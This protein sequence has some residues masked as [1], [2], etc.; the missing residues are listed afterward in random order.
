MLL[1]PLVRSLLMEHRCT[2]TRFYWKLSQHIFRYN[3][4]NAGDSTN[5]LGG[6]HTV[7][8]CQFS[9]KKHLCY[10]SNTVNL[11]PS[12]GGRWVLGDDPFLYHTYPQ[13]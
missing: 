9:C 4:H 5:S 10:N 2:D 12:Q 11:F 8:E 7:N 3:H 13:R 1:L 6:I